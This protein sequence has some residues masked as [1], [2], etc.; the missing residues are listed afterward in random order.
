MRNQEDIDPMLLSINLTNDFQPQAADQGRKKIEVDDKSFKALLGN[1]KIKAEKNL[2]AQALSNLLENAVKY[3]DSETK[4]ILG[5][6]KLEGFGISVTSVGLPITEEEKKRIF[7]RGERGVTAKQR[8]PAGT[9][10]GLY[11]ASRV[12]RLHQGT[13]TLN[14]NGKTSRFTLVFPKARIT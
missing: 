12:M 10:I 13:I 3:A 2:I 6:D 8:V 9:G 7:E 14:T 11:L 1:R 5:A 4:I